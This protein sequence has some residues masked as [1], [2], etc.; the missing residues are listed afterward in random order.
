MTWSNVFECQGN[1]NIF[2][3]QTLASSFNF[4]F[5]KANVLF[6]LAAL[7]SQLGQLET[8]TNVESMKRSS[9]YFQV[10]I[11]I[12]VNSM[13]LP[14]FIILSMNCVRPSFNQFLQI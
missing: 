7:Y 13:R 6:C 12:H 5:E 11:N 9:A 10:F 14:Y 2:I 3:I 8:R 4:V 1:G